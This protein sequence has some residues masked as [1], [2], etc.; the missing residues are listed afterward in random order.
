MLC[1]G[2]ECIVLQTSQNEVPQLSTFLYSTKLLSLRREASV[3]MQLGTQRF[4]NL[5]PIITLC[6]HTY[7]RSA[8]TLR[9]GASIQLFFAFFLRK[10]HI[11]PLFYLF[12]SIIPLFYISATVGSR[13]MALFGCFCT[14]FMVKYQGGHGVDPCT[15]DFN[16]N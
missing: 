6:F 3:P 7:A 13:F 15:K 16:L 2:T 5:S 9:Y 8:K 1:T 14:D 12:L 10:L 4:L 11:F